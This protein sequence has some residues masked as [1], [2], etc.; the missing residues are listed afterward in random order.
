M[1]AFS[2]ISRQGCHGLIFPSLSRLSEVEALA[3]YARPLLQIALWSFL[4]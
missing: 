1:V 3:K 2:T 4:K